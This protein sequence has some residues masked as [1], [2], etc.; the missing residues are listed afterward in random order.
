MPRKKPTQP[1][2]LRI[3][4]LAEVMQRTGKS[5]SSI[6]DAISRGMFPAPCPLGPRSVGWSEQEITLYIEQCIAA[7]NDGSANA[8]RSLPLAGSGQR[9][10]IEASPQDVRRRKARRAARL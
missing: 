1:Q 7:R 3:L 8:V 4:R 6:Y 2:H 10:K 5:R 9:R